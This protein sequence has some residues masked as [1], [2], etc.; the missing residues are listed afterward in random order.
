MSKDVKQREQTSLR[1]KIHLIQVIWKL[2]CDDKAKTKL[3]KHTKKFRQ[4]YGEVNQESYEIG[5]DYANH[6]KEITLAE[7]PDEKPVDSKDRTPENL[8]KQRCKKG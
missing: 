5:A 8:S 1:N 6:T 4:M 2:Q 7:T 3:S